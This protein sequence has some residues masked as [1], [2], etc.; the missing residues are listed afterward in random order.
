MDGQERYQ[1]DREWKEFC[2][3]DV[4]P[5]GRCSRQLW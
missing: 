2:R 3:D 1:E 4:G 5:G